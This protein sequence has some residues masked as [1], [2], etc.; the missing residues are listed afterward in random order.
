MMNSNY[1][2]SPGPRL[3][4]GSG[5]FNRSGQFVFV[6]AGSQVPAS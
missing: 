3:A 4:F 6:D 5:V 2:V 1:D